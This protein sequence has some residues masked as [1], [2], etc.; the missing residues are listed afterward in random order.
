MAEKV[1]KV[2]MTYQDVVDQ[3]LILPRKKKYTMRDFNKLHGKYDAITTRF[4]VICSAATYKVPVSDIFWNM[5]HFL[6]M[7]DG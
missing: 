4:I 2:I 7:P 5:N 6:Y 1:E 3:G